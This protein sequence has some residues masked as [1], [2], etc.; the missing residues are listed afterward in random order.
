MALALSILVAA[1]LGSVPTGFLIA[2]ARGIDLRT[3]GSGNIGAT[4]LGRVLG[5]N[6]FVLCFT[7]DAL[8]GLVPT[9][10]YGL[11]GGLAG[12]LDLPAGDVAAWLGVMLAPVLGH[13]FCPWLGFKGGKGVATGLGALLGVAPVLTIAGLGGLAVWLAVFKARGIVSLASIAAAASVPLVVA[14]LLLV[15]R[16][17]VGPRAWG[18]ATLAGWWPYLVLTTALAIFVIVRHRANIAR[19]RAGTEARFRPPDTRR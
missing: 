15:G 3:R 5:R 2:R 1:L 6:A 14:A 7:L 4:N 17:G 12:R 11:W 19:L 10:A 18:T 13:M 16:A 9:L 8:K